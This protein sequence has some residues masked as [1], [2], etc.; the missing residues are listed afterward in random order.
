MSSEIKPG[1]TI[2]RKV[3]D[4]LMV[5]QEWIAATKSWRCSYREDDGQQIIEDLK[6]HLLEKVG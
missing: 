2:V 5:V 6:P 4:R 3:D 1:D